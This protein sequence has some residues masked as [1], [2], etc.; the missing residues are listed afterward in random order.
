MNAALRVETPGP[1]STLQDFGRRGWRRF[2][3]PVSGAMDP[4]ALSIANAL[5]G[6]PPGAAAVELTLIGGS[7]VVEG[8]AVRIALAGGDF[9][10]FIDGSPAAAACSHTLEAGQS[11][12][13]GSTRHGVR[14]YLAAA[15]GFAIE[16]MLD[17]RSTHV[18]SGLGG[19]HGGPLAAGDR[20]PLG[21]AELAVPDQW[22]PP[23]HMPHAFPKVRVV[24][25]PQDDHFTTQAIARFQATDYTIS[26]HS[27]RM[28]YRL[29]GPPLEHSRGFDIISDATVP[30][31]IQVPGTGEPIVL[32]ADAQTT[33]GYPKIA[34]VISADLPA[35]GQCRP[36]DHLRFEA[37]TLE[38]AVAARQALVRWLAALPRVLVPVGRGPNPERLLAANLIGGVT[39]GDAFL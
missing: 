25:G 28:G 15:G 18:R 20:L 37:V 23:E 35:L 29:S 24:L 36:G 27:D 12:R 22:L 32:M 38:A 11:V 9:P 31:S 34:T 6:N 30:G 19:I 10:M 26:P 5:V 33:G 2:G 17:S 13:I 39:D 4:V 3:V 1:L 21:E 7:F 8:A 14:G 16:A